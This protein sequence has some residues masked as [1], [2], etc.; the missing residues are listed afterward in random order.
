MKYVDELILY[1]VFILYWVFL[2]DEREEFDLDGS[3]KM[4]FLRKLYL[5]FFFCF[6]KR[7][8]RF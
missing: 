4:V 3:F 5:N 7:L 2:E 8:V 6:L 1:Y